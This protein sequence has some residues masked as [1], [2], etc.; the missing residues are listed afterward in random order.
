MERRKRRGGEKKT[1]MEREEKR[2][3]RGGYNPIIYFGLYGACGLHEKYDPFSIL[4]LIIV[5]GSL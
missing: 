3:G 4:P 5:L 1:E 2:D